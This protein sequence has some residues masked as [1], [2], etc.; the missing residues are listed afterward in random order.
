[1]SKKDGLR[2]VL[3]YDLHKNQK[4]SLSFFQVVS[5]FWRQFRQ[6]LNRMPFHDDKYSPSSQTMSD[7]FVAEPLNS[8]E[9]ELEPSEH[10]AAHWEPGVK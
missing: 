10:K 8:E 7:E 2:R 5:L 4:T 6:F 9:V 3:H 1:M